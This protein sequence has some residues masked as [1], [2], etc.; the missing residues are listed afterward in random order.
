MKKWLT[1]V[2]D[3]LLGAYGIIAFFLLWEMAPRLG[4][5][6]NYLFNWLENNIVNW[7][8]ESTNPA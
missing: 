5:A 2:N 3:K 4:L 8:E 7:K 6:I 1:A